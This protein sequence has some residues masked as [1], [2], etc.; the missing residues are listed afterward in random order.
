MLAREGFTGTPAVTIEGDEAGAWWVDLGVRWRIGEQYFKAYPVCRWA[1][2]AV[3]AA[4]ELQREHGFAAGD[5]ETIAIESFREAVALGSQCPRPRTTEEAQYSITFPVAAALVF[6]RLGADEVDACG[7]EDARVQR[8]LSQIALAE[9][10]EFARRFPAERWARVRIAL[11]DGRTLV[12][13]PAR[14]RGNPENPIA[15]VELRAKYRALAE[16]VLGEARARRIAEAVDALATESGA[17]ARLLDDL[18]H[19]PGG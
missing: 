11:A 17:L 14:A 7:I 13:E 1:Q 12:S 6:G 4:L 5:I 18:L 3:E 2:P 16:P 8:L 15:D 10:D 19:P 9:N